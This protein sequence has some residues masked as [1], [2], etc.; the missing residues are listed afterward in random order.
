M[1]AEN[2][3]PKGLASGDAFCNRIDERQ[4][5]A[6]N[7]GSGLHTLLIS[8]RRYGKTSLVRE[9]ISDTKIVCGDA[10]LF[11]AI[12]AERIQQRI[13]AAVKSILQKI[14]NSIEQAVQL[15]TNSFKNISA[16]WM[17]GTQGLGV[18]LIPQQLDPASAIMEA[19]QALENSLAQ[20][21]IRAVMFIDEVQEIGEIAE[22]RGIEGAI[23]HVAQQT[24]YLSFVFSGSNR[25]L[26]ANMF[27]DKARPLYQLCERMNLDRIDA[28][29]YHRHLNKLAKRYWKQPLN[30]NVMEAILNVTERHPYYV[31]ALCLKLWQSSIKTA[32]TLKKVEETW[33]KLI[34]ES[35]QEIIR[36]INVLSA[37]QRR[38]LVAIANGFNKE[39]TGKQFLKQ[40]GL[41]S[42]SVLTALQVLE[43]K[44]YLRKNPQTHQYTILDPVISGILRYYFQA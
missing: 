30:D 23:R 7:I 29:A 21:K 8:P 28:S 10:D 36:E 39:L 41:T 33:F 32:P 15:L 13:L 12:D 40:I 1:K 25:H 19:L 31:N 27:Y 5:L 6:Q 16:K 2:Y 22:N 44:D 26:L 42:S 34:F 20:K 3:F 17:I 24:Q 43:Q 9:V 18:E 35:K 14:S 37:G 11:V 38:I 4:Q